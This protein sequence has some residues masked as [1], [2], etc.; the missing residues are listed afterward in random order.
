MKEFLAGLELGDD[1]RLYLFGRPVHAAINDRFCLN[2]V[3]HFGHQVDLS[4]WWTM[5]R[6]FLAGADKGVTYALLNEFLASQADASSPRSG[7][8]EVATNGGPAFGRVHFARAF[9]RDHL[10]ATVL[11]WV[12]AGRKTLIKPQGTGLGH[13]IRFFLSDEEREADI[14]TR[15]DESLRETE[16]L[17]G[18][19]GG[20][21]P[22]TVCEF[23]DTCTIQRDHHALKGH[24]FEIRV[25][26]YRDGGWLKAFPSITKIAS[27]AYDAARPAHLSLINN[28]T[29]SAQAKKTAGVEF[30]MPLS[31]R[32]T[33]DTLGLTVADLEHVCAAGTRFVRYLLDT[34]EDRP[35]VF[36]LPDGH[37][38]ALATDTPLA[39]VHLS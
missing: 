20:A 34:L 33:V 4:Q 22:Y 14:I 19:K 8:G 30:M 28:I 11:D 23:L 27:E 1:G 9:E 38:L 26:V 32:E 5:N 25:V 21:L 18:L 31:R 13:G 2:V 36:G 37:A 39:G 35:W 7:R 10:V 15:I 29:T 3:H 16:A 6:A 17:Y 12:R 24:K